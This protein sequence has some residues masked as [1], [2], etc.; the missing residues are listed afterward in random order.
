MQFQTLVKIDMV[1]MD[2]TVEWY[3][4]ESHP[5]N[6]QQQIT[7]YANWQLLSSSTL[8]PY[9]GESVSTPFYI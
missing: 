3:V 8:A 6:E 9:T 5:A 7:V 1:E 2:N 4:N